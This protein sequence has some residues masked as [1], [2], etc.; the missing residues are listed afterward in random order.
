[1]CRSADPF[2]FFACHNDRGG[3]DPDPD[4][5]AP[6]IAVLAALQKNNRIKDAAELKVKESDRIAVMTENLKRMAQ[7]SNRRTT[8]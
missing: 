7:M 1:M 4:R 6:V 5:R 8:E 3:T 2:L